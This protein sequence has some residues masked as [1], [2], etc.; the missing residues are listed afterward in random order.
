VLYLGFTAVAAALLAFAWLANGPAAAFDAAGRNAVHA[1][2]TPAL[3]YVMLGI[4]QL[5]S[6]P[7]L[8]GVGVLA[9]RRLAAAGRKE[10][11][12][13]LAVAT[14]GGEALSQI[15]K[16]CFHRSRPDAF[17]GLADPATYS[18]PSG[19]AFTATCFYATLAAVLAARTPSVAAKAG[20]WTL[21]GAMAALI[22]LSRVYLG[23]HY[24]SDVLGGYAAAVVWVVAV[25]AAY[26]GWRR[27]GRRAAAPPD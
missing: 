24:P 7:F 20:L 3:T 18:F 13:L 6:G 19:H 15:L 23:V 8:I 14:L 11:A 10:A 5:G 17:F 9:I 12:V 2:A 21:A 16:L 25:R 4:T 22:G 27:R 26:G 1:W